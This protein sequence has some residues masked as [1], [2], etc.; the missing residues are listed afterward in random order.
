MLELPVAKSYNNQSLLTPYIHI[1][2][3]AESRRKHVLPTLRS[4]P[5]DL[6]D[7]LPKRKLEQLPPPLHSQILPHLTPPHMK[8]LFFLLLR[9]LIL[10][11]RATQHP[12]CRRKITPLFR[13]NMHLAAQ[14]GTQLQ[15]HAAS[16][17]PVVVCS[18]RLAHS[19]GEGGCVLGRGLSVA[20]QVELVEDFVVV[21]ASGFLACL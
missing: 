3:K 6:R 2:P 12:Q 8:L 13:L 17:W 16:D 15:L 7:R 9:D 18:G 19:A 5:L 11:A 14:T 1:Q 20:A 10:R 4:H 21:G